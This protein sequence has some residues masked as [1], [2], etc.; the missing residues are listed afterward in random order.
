MFIPGDMAGSATRNLD[1]KKGMN[2]LAM[3]FWLCTH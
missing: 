3:R 2:F 1:R